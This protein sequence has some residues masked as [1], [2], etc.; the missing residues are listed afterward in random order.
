[1]RVR[2]SNTVKRL[3]IEL[4]DGG[5]PLINEAQDKS[6]TANFSKIMGFSPGLYD[7]VPAIYWPALIPQ[8]SEVSL[9]PC[10]ILLK[11]GSY[12]RTVMVDVIAGPNWSPEIGFTKVRV[13]EAFGLPPTFMICP[14]HRLSRKDSS[15][16][17]I[18]S[19]TDYHSLYDLEDLVL[20]GK[21]ASA[22]AN[23]PE[24][25]CSIP[26]VFGRIGLS[27]NVAR[28]ISVP[29]DDNARLL[30]ISQMAASTPIV[31]GPDFSMAVHS[32][33]GGSL[34]YDT[35]YWMS[36]VKQVYGYMAI[37]KEVGRYRGPATEYQINGTLVT[38]GHT[39]LLGADQEIKARQKT[40]GAL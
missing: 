26:T 33:F 34:V 12:G 15:W 20:L 32:R 6:G 18:D 9:H 1:M 21:N 24:N 23:Q 19:N 4:D 14:P 31:P 38:M 3:T 11:H 37:V 5:E 7:E 30:L 25:I 39:I 8:I 13:S 2:S 27:S 40:K 22:S 10:K 29:R 28:I 17:T 36:I 16:S 35:V